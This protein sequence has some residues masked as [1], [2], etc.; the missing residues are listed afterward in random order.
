MGGGAAQSSEDRV[1]GTVPRRGVSD[2]WCRRGESNPNWQKWR[3]VAVFF[4]VSSLMVTFWCRRA[5]C[6]ADGAFGGRARCFNGGVKAIRG[7][8]LHVRHDMRVEIHR[9][10]DVGMSESLLNNLR[11]LKVAEH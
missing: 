9:H 1:S 4:A 10:S 3:P 8:P 11:M 5:S 6:G 7:L 2:E